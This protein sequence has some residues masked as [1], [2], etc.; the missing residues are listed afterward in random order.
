MGAGNQVLLAGPDG[1]LVVTT[2]QDLSG[3]AYPEASPLPGGGIAAMSYIADAPGIYTVRVLGAGSP[4]YTGLG[5]TLEL[6][7]FR[8]PLESSK[9]PKRIFV[10]FDGATIDP[11]I[12]GGSGGPTSLSPLSSFLANWGLAPDDEDAVIDATLAA[13][14]ENLAIDPA[15]LGPNG[16]FGVEILNS[17]DHPDPFGAPDVSR[18]IVG[19]TI[20]ELGLPTIG[21]AQSI[22]PGNFETAETA[23]ILLD[24]L[25][26]PAPDP[27]SL[28]SFPLAPGVSIID[29][30][31]VALGNIAAHEAGHITGNYHTEQF[32]A[33]ASLMDRGG[34]LPNTLGVGPDGIF[35]NA[36][37]LD[38][39]F[40]EDQFEITEGFAGLENTLAVIGCGCTT[41]IDIFAD[42]FESGNLGQ[43]SSSVP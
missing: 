7:L 39:D 30:I 18:L 6:R 26:R 15:V 36:D 9:D 37:D 14:E 4:G 20:P 8:Q 28:N 24:L 1:E 5:Y 12:F 17:R 11:A 33:L 10:D 42:G 16:A 38:V 19:G 29:F 32:N 41:D 22:D 25:S 35:G 21:I 27:D 43:W 34:N 3:I 40:N 2:S 23:V 13:L 31:G